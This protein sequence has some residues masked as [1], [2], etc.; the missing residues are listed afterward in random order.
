VNLTIDLAPIC[1]ADLPQLLAWRNDWR[2][3]KWTR[4]P[5]YINEVT[6]AE[7]FER[8]AKDPTI[9]MYK[10]VLKSAGSTNVVGVCGLTSIDAFNRRA[11]FSLYVAPAFQGKGIGS[12]ALKILLAH[13]FDNLGLNLIWGETFDGNPATKI[14]EKVGMTREGTRRQF[15]WR[16][17]R[18]ID[19]HLYSITCED[20]YGRQLSAGSSPLRG[21]ADAATE[22][23]DPSPAAAPPEAAPKRRGRKPRVAAEP[24]AAVHAPA[25]EGGFVPWKPDGDAA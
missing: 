25:T 22:R 13:G 19:A 6:H 18:F 10:L 3:I 17:G 2:I 20:W 21:D 24:A 5:D 16:D 1:R 11:E 12:T 15:Y 8:Q 4:Q 7:W 9:R 14:F 23:S